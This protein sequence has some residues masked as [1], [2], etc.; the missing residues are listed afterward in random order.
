MRETEAS[1][2]LLAPQEF[3]V[4]RREIDNEHPPTGLETQRRFPQRARR[5]IE[6]MQ[7]LMQNDGIE[8]LHLERQRIDIALPQLSSHARLRQ[9][10]ARNRQHRVTGI[11]TDE[12]IGTISQ[13]LQHA[14]SASPKIEKRTT[15]LIGKRGAHS[16]LNLT[17]RDMKGADAIPF[18]GMARKI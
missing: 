9:L 6:E 8:T 13:N 1:M 7:H 10:R 4:V 17:I 12:A 16:R 18:D 15:R 3:M 5:I 11:N 2:R 14:A